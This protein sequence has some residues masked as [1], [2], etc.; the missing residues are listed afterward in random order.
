MEWMYAG[1]VACKGSIYKLNLFLYSL[2]SC[3][4]L[5]LINTPQNIYQGSSV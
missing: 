2:G 4:L 3:L 5:I 1:K